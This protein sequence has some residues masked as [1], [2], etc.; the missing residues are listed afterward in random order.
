MVNALIKLFDYD[1]IHDPCNMKMHFMAQYVCRQNIRK[2][3]FEKN[4]KKYAM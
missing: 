3:G 2:I 4:D 1:M